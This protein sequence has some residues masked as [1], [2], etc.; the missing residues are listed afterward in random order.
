[1]PAAVVKDGTVRPKFR[2]A[3]LSG[4][5]PH[6]T[7]KT[8]YPVNPAIEIRSSMWRQCCPIRN[9]AAPH[10]TGRAPRPPKDRPLRGR[11]PHVRH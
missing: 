11:A 7:C 2:Q 9:Q 5:V 6:S 8:L 1:M 3:F 4:P 10:G